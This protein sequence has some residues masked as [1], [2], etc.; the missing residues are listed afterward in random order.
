M[1]V[2]DQPELGK[3][4]SVNA[5]PPVQG[6]PAAAKAE[7]PVVEGVSKMVRPPVAEYPVLAVRRPQR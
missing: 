4:D 2:Q 5:D 6:R 3:A 7:A 1:A